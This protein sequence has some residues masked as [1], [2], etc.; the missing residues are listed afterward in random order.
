MLPEENFTGKKILITDNNPVNV[1]IVKKYLKQWDVDSDVAENGKIACDKV[2][3]N[4]YDLVLMDIQ[5]PVMDGYEASAAIRNMEGD[6]FKHLPI[7]ALSASTINEIKE[8]ILKSG[9]DGCL[10]KPFTPSQLYSILLVYFNK[11]VLK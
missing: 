9:I 6:K 3:K 8:E 4:D 1:K 5:M 11:I 2:S 10:T 7:I